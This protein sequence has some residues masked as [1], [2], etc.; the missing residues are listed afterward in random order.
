MFCVPTSLTDRR[1]SSLRKILGLPP[2]AQALEDPDT[3][4]QTVFERFGKV[5][6]AWRCLE[7]RVVEHLLKI[8]SQPKRAAERTAHSDRPFRD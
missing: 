5:A 6:E 4:G 2:L 1:G 7:R 8:R 3:P